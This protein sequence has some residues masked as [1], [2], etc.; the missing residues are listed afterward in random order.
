MYFEYRQQVAC[1][2]LSNSGNTIFQAFFLIADSPY[3]LEGLSPMTSYNLQFSAMNDVGMS[4]WAAKMEVV[5]PKRSFPEEPKILNTVLTEEKYAVSPY[6][7][8]F[9]LSW[10]KPADN[11]EPIDRYDIKYCQVITTDVLI[12]LYI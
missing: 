3:I 6:H 11:G 4:N 12:I 5:M 2:K 1:I 9:E 7:N 8:R 10:R